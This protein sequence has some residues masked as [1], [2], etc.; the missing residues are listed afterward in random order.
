MAFYEFARIFSLF[1]RCQHALEGGGK[2]M[3]TDQTHLL[4]LSQLD[5]ALPNLLRTFFDG[6]K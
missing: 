4:K 1:S 3:L 5:A 6:L 2:Q